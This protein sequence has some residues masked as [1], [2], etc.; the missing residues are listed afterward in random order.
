M[1]SKKADDPYPLSFNIHDLSQISE[2][3]DYLKL[4][5]ELFQ[6]YL[7]DRP[8]F[9]GQGLNDDELDYF[10]YYLKHGDFKDILSKT[11]SLIP[12]SYSAIFDDAYREKSQQREAGIKKS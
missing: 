12:P 10:G 2:F 7:I 3:K 1:T 11:P 6:S 4:S 9:F 5:P 8:S